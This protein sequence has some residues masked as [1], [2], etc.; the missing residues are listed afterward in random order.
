VRQKTGF[1]LAYLQKRFLFSFSV[2]AK[3]TG[4]D[5]LLGNRIFVLVRHIISISF[6]STDLASTA[7]KTNKT[8]K[9]RSKAKQQYLNQL[10]SNY[11]D[12][13]KN[14]VVLNCKA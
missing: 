7:F 9:R 14:D 4:I 10:A 2:S 5:S 13:A 12:V 6:L 11:V 8:N 1:Q 3:N